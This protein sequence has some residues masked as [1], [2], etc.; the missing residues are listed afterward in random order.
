MFN[1]P[2][3]TYDLNVP[4]SIIAL[5]FI[6]PATGQKMHIIAPS[7]PSFE[8][9]SR[10]IWVLEVFLVIKGRFKRSWPYFIL[11]FRLISTTVINWTFGTSAE[12]STFSFSIISLKLEFSEHSSQQLSPFSHL[13]HLAK[14]NLWLLVIYFFFK[15]DGFI[16]VTCY[17]N[18]V[19]TK[20]VPSY[21]EAH[22]SAKGNVKIKKIS[23]T[24]CLVY[25]FFNFVVHDPGISQPF[26]ISML[27]IISIVSSKPVTVKVFCDR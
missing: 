20:F 5:Y 14:F 23:T 12:Y 6:F 1:I 16:D 7:Q 26:W 3:V 21:P 2:Y 17:I 9:S 15:I 4:A 11:L 24:R 25:S 19:P 22:T 27:L 8:V 18:Y 10:E 13:A